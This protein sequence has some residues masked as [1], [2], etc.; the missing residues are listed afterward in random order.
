MQ[1][2]WDRCNTSWKRGQ[3]DDWFASK[4]IITLTVTTVLGFFFFLWRE[5]TYANPI[6]AL[7]VLKNGNLRIGTILSFILGLGLYGS[8]FIIPLYTQSL[9]GWTAQQSGALMIPAAITT[10]FMMP[11]VG[12]MLTRGAKPQILVAIGM[13]MFSAFCYIGY[14]I[15]TPDTSSG[16]FFWMLILRGLGMGMLFIPITALSLSSLKG[17]E[18]GQGASFTGMARQLGGSFGVALISTF[19]ARQNQ[20]H[21]ADLLGNYNTTSPAFQS[22]ITQLQAGFMS[23]GMS[24]NIALQTAYQA[25]DGKIL[26]QSA[27]LSY[28]DVFLYLCVMFAICVPFV[29]MVR[30]RKGAVVDKEAM[31]SAH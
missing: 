14:T 4:T 31:A 20:I 8:T 3:E 2:S 7:R 27:V 25:L 10:A 23:K 24:P 26:R 5:L 29:L 13:V 12:Q 19:M 1:F 22:S 21:R 17:Q 16:N 30:Q 6:V 11:M 15:I 18:I 9:L 28:M